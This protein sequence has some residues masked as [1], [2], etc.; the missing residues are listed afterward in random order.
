MFA[1]DRVRIIDNDETLNAFCLPGGFIYVYTG[2]IKYL[3]SEDHLAGVLGHEIAHA[4][5][6]EWRAFQASLPEQPLID[7]G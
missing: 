2:L 6:S 3:D 7:T 1:F 4:D 5:Q